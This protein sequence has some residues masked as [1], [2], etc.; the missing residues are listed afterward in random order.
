ME[1]LRRASNFFSSSFATVYRTPEE[2][3]RAAVLSEVFN[4]SSNL[5]KSSRNFCHSLHV[6]SILEENAPSVNML[7]QES[8]CEGEG[9][10]VAVEV[11]RWASLTSASSPWTWRRCSSSVCPGLWWPAGWSRTPSRWNRR[12]SRAAG[13]RTGSARRPRLC[14]ASRCPSADPEDEQ[15]YILLTAALRVEWR[16]APAGRRSVGSL[17]TVHI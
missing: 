4:H 13:P 3:G 16:T 7:H 2:L 12:R 14:C 11:G 17:H 8:Q 1:N 6:S 15:Q 5:E 9:E 10:S